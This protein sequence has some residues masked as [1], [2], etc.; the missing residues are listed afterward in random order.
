VRDAEAAFV[1]GLDAT[2]YLDK[3]DNRIEKTQTGDVH[4]MAETDRVYLDTGTPL[5]LFDRAGSRRTDIVKQNS[6]TTVVWNPWMQKAIELKDLGAE[7]WRSFVCIETSNVAPLSVQIGPGE[8]HT[9]AAVI[10]AAPFQD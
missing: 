10:S 3:T 4:L 6:R 8:T 2:H 7:Q 5:Q 9:I 1:R